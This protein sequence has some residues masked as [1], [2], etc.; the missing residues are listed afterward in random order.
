MDGRY[1]KRQNRLKPI[2][3]PGI[4][5]SRVPLVQAAIRIKQAERK[6]EEP[7]PVLID[8][9]R[10]CRVLAGGCRHEERADPTADPE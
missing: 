2:L 3:C 7:D 10:V 6:G 9:M 8:Y 4:R 5:N 1:E